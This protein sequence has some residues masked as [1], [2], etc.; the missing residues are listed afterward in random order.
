VDRIL[1]FVHTDE[2]A[3]HYCDYECSDQKPTISIARH[4]AVLDIDGSMTIG[5]QAYCVNCGCE[6]DRDNHEDLQC[7]SHNQRYTCAHCGCS[8]D[9]DDDEVYEY[10]G[11][12]YCC[13]C[14][15]YCDWHERYEPITERCYLMV[16]GYEIAICEDARNSYYRQCDWCGEWYREDDLNTDGTHYFCNECDEIKR[17]CSKC[18]KYLSD[19]EEDV[20]ETCK[21]IASG[22]VFVVPCDNYQVDDYVVLKKE[23]NCIYG[24]GSDMES[25]AGLVVR[26]TQKTRSGVLNLTQREG[27]WQTWNWDSGCFAG[28]VINANDSMLFRELE[29]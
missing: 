29:V 19:A 14:V 26:I 24:Q 13:D 23:F 5:H 27:A 8:V 28:K 11:E 12:Y 21:R 15:F 4:G 17:K 22:E 9:P 16:D 20:C 3:A 2:D 6:L 7:N 18:G 25:Y 10:G 1:T